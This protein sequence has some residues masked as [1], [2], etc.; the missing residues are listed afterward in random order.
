MIRRM[1]QT[2]LCLILSPLLVAQQVTAPATES[3]ATAKSPVSL[4]TANSSPRTVHIPMD[5]LVVLRLEQRVSTADAKP[6]DRVRL[7]LVNDLAV[8]GRVVVP[9]GTFCNV[10]ITGVWRASPKDP[11][12]VA[13][14]RFS[15]PKLDLG[16]GQRIQLTD[17]NYVQRHDH[18]D[19]EGPGAVGTVLLTVTAPLWVPWTVLDNKIQQAKMGRAVLAANRDW[20]PC[21]MEYEEGHRFNY[22]VR[23]TVNIR[24]DRRP[25]PSPE[26]QDN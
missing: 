24:M 4:P 15:A 16:Q 20:K 9:A 26:R 13:G 5:T 21:D 18:S 14:I 1:I 2:A 3:A 25:V 11:Y 10:T 19:G 6:G 7:T 8:G 12:L 22:Y 23:R 17:L